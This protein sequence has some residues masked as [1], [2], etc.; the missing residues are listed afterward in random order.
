MRESRRI[1]LYQLG[2]LAGVL[3]SWEIAASRSDAFLF[4]A[5]SPSTIWREFWALAITGD[6]FRHMFVTALEAIGGFLIGTFVGTTMGLSLWFSQRMARVT[7]PFVLAL[8][9]FPILAFAPLMIVWFGIGIKM[10]IAL[11]AFST[12]FVAFSQA[13]RGASEVAQEFVEMMGGMNST[14][15][16]IFKKVI[17]PGSLGWVLSSMRLNVG[18]ALLG[19]FI[20]EFIAAEMGL[21]YLILRAGSLYNVP[22]AFAASIGIT[23]LA[24]SLDLL[25]AFLERRRFKLMQIVSVPLRLVRS[26]SNG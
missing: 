9:T 12:F 10:K 22:R 2:L 3:L 15:L 16:Q 18:F 13:Y 21:G 4:V 8:G 23:I 11:A 1:A 7:R 24:L 6:L 26:R 25:A 17:V 5:G 19:A 14:K 20:G